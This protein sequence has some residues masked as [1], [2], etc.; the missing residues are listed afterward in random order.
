VRWLRAVHV[1]ARQVVADRC[2]Q[3]HGRSIT[4]QRMRGEPAPHPIIIRLAFPKPHT[5][6]SCC[7]TGTARPLV[8]CSAALIR[9]SASAGGYTEK[10]CLPLASTTESRQTRCA[11]RSGMR[12]ATPVIGIPRSCARRGRPGRAHRSG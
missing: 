3:R 1:G 12:S 4:V 2:P 5:A 6:G 8:A 10:A 7:G 9:A 11:R